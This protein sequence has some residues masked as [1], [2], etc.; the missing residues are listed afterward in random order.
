MIVCKGG[1]GRLV[2]LTVFKKSWHP[3][4]P[5]CLAPFDWLFYADGRF[6]ESFGVAASHRKKFSKRSTLLGI[7]YWR[8]IA[9]ERT[10][11][12]AQFGT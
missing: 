5:A 6:R 11:N 12:G 8:T 9:R 3:R 4:D 1:G 2:Y 7:K 10:N